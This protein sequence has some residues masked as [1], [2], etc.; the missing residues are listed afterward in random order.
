[1]DNRANSNR[2]SLAVRHYVLV[3]AFAFLCISVPFFLFQ[4]VS[5]ESYEAESVAAPEVS[6]A[7]TTLPGMARALPTRLRIPSIHIDVPFEDPP[8]G[9]NPNKTIEAPR[10]FTDVGWYQYGAAPGETGTAVVLGHVDTYQGPAV[11]YSLGQLKEGDE[12]LVDRADGTTATFLVQELHRY[13][14][15]EFPSHLVYDPTPYPSL[16]LITC[17]GVYDHGTKRYDHNLV[18]FLKLKE[19]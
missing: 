7:T 13:S 15:D 2:Q 11:F 9:L 14:Q 3:M 18:V 12:V 19:G 5:R 1:M 16:R 4:M 8:L 10:Q 6:T 17:T